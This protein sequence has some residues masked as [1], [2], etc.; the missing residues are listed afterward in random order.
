MSNLIT[1]QAQ[2]TKDLNDINKKLISLIGSN[3]NVLNLNLGNEVQS[4]I[5]IDKTKNCYLDQIKDLHWQPIV[6]KKFKK[7]FLFTGQGSQYINMGKNLFTNNPIFNKYMNVA[8]NEINKH[9][10]INLFDI[11][12]PINNECTNINQTQYTQ[13]ALFAIEYALAQ[14]WITARIKPD[15]VMGH[16]VGEFAAATIAGSLNIETGAALI[17]NR[18][19]LMQNLPQGGSMVALMTNQENA[20]EIINKVKTKNNVLNIA[21]INTPKQTVI[22]GDKA[23]LAECIKLAKSKKI[24]ARELVVSHAFHSD[25]MQPA[26]DEFYLIA[27]RYE[28]KKP[29]ISLISNLSGEIMDIAPNAKYWCEHILNP[30]NFLKSINSCPIENTIFIEIGPNPI[31]INMAKKCLPVDGNYHSLLS[32]DQKQENEA[33]TLLN[34]IG[35]CKTA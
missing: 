13:P 33:Y 4:Y 5:I 34:N 9:I 17:S 29:E 7:V 6:K 35:I 30:V 1:I 14:T 25:L 2:Q 32:I 3:E 16:S 28:M 11:I 21:A 18:A 22:S 31:L 26:I 23:S 12:F 19:R 27:S 15:I 8:V 20:Q 24:K 10:D